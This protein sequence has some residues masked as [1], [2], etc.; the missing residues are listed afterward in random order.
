MFFVN[1][2]C[3]FIYIA[4]YKIVSNS[5]TFKFNVANGAN[6]NERYKIE[7]CLFDA[8]LVI[9]NLKRKVDNVETSRHLLCDLFSGIS[10]LLKALKN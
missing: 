10:L 7:G 8:G 3:S 9:T 2:E 4:Y 5:P 6:T 1:Y